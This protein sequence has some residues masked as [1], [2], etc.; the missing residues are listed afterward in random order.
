MDMF[1]HGAWQYC[2]GYSEEN[3]IE[4]R[5]KIGR[6]VVDKIATDLNDRLGIKMVPSRCDD[7]IRDYDAIIT[8]AT[9]VPDSLVAK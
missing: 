1:S 5:L 7:Y 8:M 9:M 6:E 2:D 4:S 3:K